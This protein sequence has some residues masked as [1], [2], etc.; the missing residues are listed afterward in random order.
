MK[1]G[2][3]NGGGEIHCRE[4]ERP[5]PGPNEVL[6]EI[7]YCGI[8]GTDL[9]ILDEE[10]DVGPPP[11]V[12]G[13]E[14]SGVVVAVGDGVADELIGSEVGLDPMGVCGLCAWCLR[15][16]Y[17]HCRRKYFSASAFA[18]AALYRPHQL[19]PL[20]AGLSPRDGALLEPW[21]TALRA[22]EKARLQGGENVL[23]I[24]G[25]TLG[26][27]TATAARLL[28]AASVIVSE[29]RQENR[30]L[31]LARGADAVTD[32]RSGELPELAASSSELRGFDVIFE[33][34]GAE[35]ALTE[36]PGLLRRG[37]RLVILGIFPPQASV[38]FVV[39]GLT[40]REISVHGSFGGAGSFARAASLLPRI[41]GE[42]L[43]TSV[44]PI[45]RIAELFG[46]VRT[47]AE[48]K[49]MVRPETS[50]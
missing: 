17:T 48:V 41:D 16:Y 1:A 50:R 23:V 4:V 5:V 20:P 9:H 43:V 8:C 39:R 13:H 47:G 24:G 3:W 19:H 40:D 12:L 27:L 10:F 6:V 46:R 29:L 44:E 37:G 21:A 11:Q 49:A 7:A 18:E 34:A 26:L 31:A 36:A 45:E 42:S 22:V 35:G 15:G 14:A 32:P 30:E 25:G 33:V 38:P 28:G 2:V